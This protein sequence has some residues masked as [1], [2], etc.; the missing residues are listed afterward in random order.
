MNHMTTLDKKRMR[1]RWAHMLS[2]CYNPKDKRYARY[3]GRGITVC[4]RWAASF[5]YFCQDLG[6]PPEG[7]TLDRINNDGPYSPENCR[8]AT[9]EQQAN[10]RAQAVMLTY[11]GKTQSISQWARE[12]GLGVNTISV[13]H[14]QGQPPEQAL[15]VQRHLRLR[16]PPRTKYRGQPWPAKEA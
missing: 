6:A 10:N 11:N 14:R 7:L 2:R 13:R 1:K 15:R 16:R 5:D 9:H 8:W 4:W 12:L 3:G